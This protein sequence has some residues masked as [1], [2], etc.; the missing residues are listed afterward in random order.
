MTDTTATPMVPFTPAA[1]VA[2]YPWWVLPGLAAMV[3]LVFAG[4]LA[5][6]CALADTTLRTQMFTGAYGLATL[7][8]GYFFGSSSG[9]A[10]KDDVIAASGAAKDATIAA[11]AASLATST[12]PTGMGIAATV[13]TTKTETGAGETTTVTAPAVAP[14]PSPPPV[15]PPVQPIATMQS[16]TPP[17]V[18]PPGS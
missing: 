3:L 16:T 2:T 4:A 17:L 6:S 7:S 11:N 9:S 8:I 13:T 15:Q 12:P 1:P 5:A 10:R 18:F 14:A